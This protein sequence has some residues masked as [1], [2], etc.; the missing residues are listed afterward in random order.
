MTLSL[1]MI[2]KPKQGV[3]EQETVSKNQ[4]NTYMLIPGLKQPQSTIV[5]VECQP[6]ALGHHSD[7]C[8]QIKLL[9]LFLKKG[10]NQKVTV[11]HCNLTLTLINPRFGEGRFSRQ[12]SHA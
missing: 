10:F 7:K 3:N 9:E 2:R 1:T 12:I 11:S 6:N 5:K 4:I 8:D